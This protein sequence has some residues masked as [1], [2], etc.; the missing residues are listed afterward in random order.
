MPRIAALPTTDS[1][2]WLGRYESARSSLDLGAYPAA[3][4][5][6]TPVSWAPTACVVARTDALQEGFDARMRIG[7]DVDLC[8]RLIESGWRVRYEPA[9]EA[10]HEH[11]VRVH[12]WFLRKAALC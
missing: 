1:A 5:P 10:A 11:R 2:N 12:D 4:R 3:V 9:V 7:E 6:G 8:W